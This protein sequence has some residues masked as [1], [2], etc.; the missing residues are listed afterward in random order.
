MIDIMQLVQQAEQ[1]L[2][3]RSLSPECTASEVSAALLAAS[4]KIYTGVSISAACGIGF[5]AEASA[6]SQMITCGET[7]IIALVAIS[8]DH[9]FMPPCG[10]CRELLYQADH[11]NLEAVVVLGP[12]KVL[13][14]SEL[15]PFRWQEL[16]E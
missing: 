8:A 3:P 16:W 14:L 5:C 1:V 4:G 13:S 7:H 15:L 10:R 2:Q 12:E 11:R 6:L 9:K